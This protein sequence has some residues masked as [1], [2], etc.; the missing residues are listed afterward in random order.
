[1]KNE[2]CKF[3][4]GCLWFLL[5]WYWFKIGLVVLVIYVILS[6]DLFF[7]IS[8]QVLEEFFEILEEEL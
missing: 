5:N 3:V 2:I 6:K 1:M 7:N 4:L 8:I